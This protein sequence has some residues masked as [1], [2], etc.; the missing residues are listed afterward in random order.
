MKILRPCILHF[1]KQEG[2]LSADECRDLLMQ[3]LE[4]QGVTTSFSQ[5]ARSPR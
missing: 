4:V 2:I 1:H 3:R 5:K